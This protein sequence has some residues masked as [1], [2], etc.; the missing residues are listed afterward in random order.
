VPDHPPT[1]FRFGL[2]DVDLHSGE[3]RKQGRIIRI[4]DLPF[5]VLAA[6]LQRPLELV[7]REE[8]RSQLWPSDTFVDFDNSLNA[9]INKLRDALGD[10]A[11]SP[12]FIETLPRRGYRFIAEVT[13]TSDAAGTATP[14]KGAASSRQRN[15]AIVLAA[16]LVLAVV[17]V[18]SVWRAQRKLRLTDQDTILLADFSNTT[19]DPIFDDTLEQALRSALEQSP[20]LN[21]LSDQKVSEELRL[22]GLQQDQRVTPEI[23]REVCQRTGSKAILVGSISSL[24]THFAIGLNAISCHTAD[25]LG[26]EQIE[27]DGREHVLT[28]LGNAATRMRKKLGESLPTIQKYDAPIEQVT[29]SSLEA[30]EAY[31]AGIR[32][33]VQKGNAPAIPF[34]Q[35]AVVLDPGFAMA[36]ARLGALYS[37]IN[38]PLSTENIRKAYD[39]RGK[40][41]E[42]E[43]LYI[44][45]HYYRDVT[46]ELDKAAS[47][48]EVRQ[49]IYP[50]EDE[51]YTNLTVFY[52]QRGNYE[53]ALEEARE[54]LRLDPDDQDNYVAV[55]YIYISL[56]RLDEAQSALREAEQRHLDGGNLLAFRYG[57]AFLKNQAG[58]MDR[59]LLTSADNEAAGQFPLWRAE[60]EL[61]HGK[62]RKA[63]EVLQPL[64]PNCIQSCALLCLREAYF[65]L[66]RLA[67]SDAHAALKTDPTT[68]AHFPRLPLAL[69]LAI[70]GDVPQ[71]EKL[72]LRVGKDQPLRTDVQREWLPLIH[73]AVALGQNNP[74]AAVDLL[75]PMEPYELGS[76]E[77]MPIYERGQAYLMLGNGPAAASEFQKIIDHPGIVAANPVGV[78]A[79]LGLA[80]ALA[81]EGDTS[82]SS[83]AYQEF[84]AIWKDADPD[85]P[86]LLA[87]RS[88]YAKL[89]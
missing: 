27:A 81:I 36:Y 23:A 12:R 63:R 2:F 68:D 6:L 69:A 62:L 54:A 72:A 8:L 22:M 52:A 87:A 79:H 85:I 5:R 59:L 31:C 7:T 37:Q 61:Y 40:V 64:E 48:W 11:D 58:E 44:E 80:R 89:Q 42:R 35:R 34:F 21:I 50:R 65:G 47:L 20:F 39:L 73:A 67:R 1:H 77:L 13:A 82:K 9:A 75:R 57:V 51:S 38:P 76:L 4:Q 78:L 74:G 83:T 24:G 26:S 15:I 46:G 49:Q 41:S 18:A 60:V 84:F 55:V 53:K 17:G 70:A 10:S 19:G 45:A 33:Y 16:I 29:T 30:L 32:V 28:Q 25:N 3:L 56:N 14:G 86:I 43:R 88:E 71:A 66:T